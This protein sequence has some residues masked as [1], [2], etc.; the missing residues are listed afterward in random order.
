MKP[1]FLRSM[2]ARC[3]LTKR[4]ERNFKKSSRVYRLRDEETGTIITA[5]VKKNGHWLIAGMKRTTDA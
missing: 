4:Q 3:Q 5:Y 2:L 1:V